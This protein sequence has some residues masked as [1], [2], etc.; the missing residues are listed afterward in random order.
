M[1]Y[2]KFIDSV[3]GNIARKI[4]D[5]FNENDH[6]RDKGGKFT[7]KGGEGKGGS[8]RQEHGFYGGK[9][10]KQEDPKRGDELNKYAVKLEKAGVDPKEIHRL[11]REGDLEGM[12]KL[13]PETE[14]EK[15]AKEELASKNVDKLVS[16]AMEGFMDDHELGLDFL[17]A[18]R[19]RTKD[20]YDE[21]GELDE[22][23][24]S[25]R[26]E[27]AIRNNPEKAADNLE[28]LGDI[29][30]EEDEPEEETLEGLDDYGEKLLEYASD[31]DTANDA[32]RALNWDTNDYDDLEQ[33]QTA[34]K[35]AISQNPKA[36]KELWE[37]TS[38]KEEASDYL[39][40]EGDSPEGKETDRI[41]EEFKGSGIDMYAALSDL[42]VDVFN[43]PEAYLED[44][45]KE[46]LFNSPK[47][48]KKAASYIKQYRGTEDE[49]EWFK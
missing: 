32:L 24:Y 28:Q 22:D 4:E 6:P 17:K 14:T 7:T 40:Y 29:L 31:I 33:A 10:V 44:V 27:K 5:E 45:F 43:T 21:E 12:K 36:A 9:K 41:Y 23:A 13:L 48:R 20:L 25:D 1:D 3:V 2:K 49:E 15:A 46:K 19:V 16:A 38:N 8:R 35:E 39:K 30:Y 47:F 34:L 37:S 11:N 18:M 42:G 26:I